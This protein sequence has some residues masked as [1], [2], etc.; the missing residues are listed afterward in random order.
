MSEYKI[1]REHTEYAKTSAIGSKEGF[2]M[3]VL[4]P[5]L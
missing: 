2:M 4:M 5:P 1:I 3:E